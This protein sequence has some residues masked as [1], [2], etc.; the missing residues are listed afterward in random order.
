MILTG[1]IRGKPREFRGR[2]LVNPAGLAINRL[3][4][5]A[6]L[7]RK[8]AEAELPAHLEERLFGSR[9]G[10]RATRVV[11]VIAVPKQTKKGRGKND[12]PR[13]LWRDRICL[14]CADLDHLV[15]LPRGDAALTRRARKYSSLSAVVLKWSQARK[16]YE[17]Q[18]LLVEEEGLE[19]AEGEC[20][21]DAEV[22]EVRRLRRAE[23]EA[24]LDREYVERFA[25]RVRELVP[26]CPDGCERVIAEHACRKYSGRVGRSA[27]AK[28]LD[29]EAVWLAVQAHVRH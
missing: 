22:R 2:L 18:G 5:V 9:H 1:R 10:R 15:F 7:A 16:R 8:V 25:A 21:A 23:R 3:G 27:G 20:L 28:A 12:K 6:T 24:E 4:F 26:R 14:S 29:E 13:G 17:R 19:R 11:E